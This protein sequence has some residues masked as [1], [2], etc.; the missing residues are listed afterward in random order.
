MLRMMDEKAKPSRGRRGRTR[1]PLASKG[2]SA[3]SSHE[4]ATLPECFH[5]EDSE[6]E[7][8]WG[9]PVGFADRIIGT[10]YH[11]NYA[12]DSS[13]KD[14]LFNS[15]QEETDDEDFPGFTRYQM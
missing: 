11:I 8:F 15:S 14:V 12:L 9:F 13:R 4:S 1:P 6:G 7:D 2:H 3:P 5:S 10:G